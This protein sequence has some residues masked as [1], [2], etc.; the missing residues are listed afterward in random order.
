M[1]SK[2]HFQKGLFPLSILLLSL[3]AILDTI[4]THRSQRGGN[5]SNCYQRPFSLS[6]VYRKA[7]A[8]V[9]GESRESESKAEKSGVLPGLVPL[10]TLVHLFSGGKKEILE[11]LRTIP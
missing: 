11:N 4:E 5:A 9:A 3:F 6:P 1:K 10:L 2:L 7:E 8:E